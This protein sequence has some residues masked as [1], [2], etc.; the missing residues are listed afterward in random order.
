MSQAT[1]EMF[2]S[3]RLRGAFGKK[4]W[5]WSKAT[6]R[7]LLHTLPYVA[8]LQGSTGAAGKTLA[9]RDLLCDSRAGLPPSLPPCL[10]PKQAPPS[11]A[12]AAAL[13]ARDDGGLL[14]I[15][16]SFRGRRKRTEE[17]N[18]GRQTL[19]AKVR[20][21]LRGGKKKNTRHQRK[22]RKQESFHMSACVCVTG[23]RCCSGS[24][25]GK[26]RRSCCSAAMIVH[27]ILRLL[28]S[29]GLHLSC[30][31]LTQAR[32]PLSSVTISKS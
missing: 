21:R 18:R 20:R 24:S 19:E 32:T 31:R 2:A 7:T 1:T 27:L 3:P 25:E 9:V 13:E 22:G 30:L 6:K 10:P 8:S 15:T 4:N 12:S 26:Q 16:I 5:P 29:E 17:R 14:E 11:P 28:R 23:S